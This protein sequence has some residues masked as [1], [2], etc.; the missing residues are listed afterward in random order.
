M[1]SSCL[2]CKAGYFCPDPGQKEV[3]ETDKCPAG[4][5]CIEGTTGSNKYDNQCDAG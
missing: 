3:R 5:Y 2:L 4:Y 1:P